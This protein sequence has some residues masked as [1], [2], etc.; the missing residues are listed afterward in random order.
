[1]EWGDTAVLT[2]HSTIIPRC[3]AILMIYV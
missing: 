2:T 1:M 3:A